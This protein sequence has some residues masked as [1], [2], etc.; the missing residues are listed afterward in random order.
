MIIYD[1]AKLKE[2]VNNYHSNKD[3]RY[4]RLPIEA[5]KTIRTLRLNRKRRR[6]RYTCQKRRDAKANH[7]GSRPENLTKI[8]R[9]DQKNS[10]NIILGTINIQSIKSKELQLIDLLENYSL[11]ALMVTET[12]LTN[13]EHG[14]QWLETTPLNRNP[15]SLVHTN[16]PNGRGGGLALITKNCYT[17]T[18]VKNGQY[19]SFEHATWEFNVKHKQIHITGIYHPPY[20]LR[21]KSTNRAFLDDF[22]TFVTELLPRWSNNLLVGD[23]NLHV[24][25]DDDIDSTIFLDTIEAMGLYQHVTFPTHKQGNTLDLVISELGNTSKVMTTAP[26]PFLTDHRVVIS[27][28]NIKSSQ[29]KRQQIKV[30]K[31]KAVETNQWEKEFNHSN[32]TLT[33][34]LEKDVESLATELRRVLDTLAP[35]KNCSVSL[36]PKKPWFNHDL[37]VEKA[38]VRR[39]EKK[40]LK[41]KLSSTWTAYKKTRNSYYAQLNN[42]KKKNICNQIMDC[43]DD[44]KKRFTLVNNLTNKPEPQKWPKHNTKEDLAEDFA[45]FFQNKILKIRELF[46]GMKQYEAITDSSV[47]LLRKFAP[48]TEKQISL[49]I[50]QMKSKTCELDDIPTNILK[51]ILPVVCP[52]ITKI[53]NTSLTNGEFST[54]WKTAVVRPL[55]KK[56][57]LEL[58]KQNFR[59]VSNLAFISKIVERAMLLQLSQHCQDFNLQPD[60]QSAYRPDYSCE[61]AILKISNDILWAFENK[62]ITALV[63]I[64]LSAAFDTVDHEILLQILN[65][66]Y[67]ITG[68]A[69][70]WFDNYLSERSF[71]VVIGDKY[72]KPHGLTVSVPQGSC[73]GASVFNLYCS[74]LHEIIPKDLTLSGFADDHSVRRTFRADSSKDEAE[75]NRTL[76]NCML[77]IKS[78]MDSMH[79][80]MNP[81]KTEFIYFGSK[82]QLKK[83]KIGSLKVSEDLI[84]RADMIR[85]LGVYLD[86]NLNYK[87]HVTKKCKAAMLNYFKIKSIRPLLDVKTMARLCLSLCISHLDYCNS[88]LYGLPDT[89]FNRLQ[90][91]QN[92]CARLTLRRGKMDSI[93][94][95]LKELHWLPIKQRIQYKILTLTH[96]CV[97]KIGPKYLQDLIRLRPPT[98][99]GLRS[100]REVNLLVRPLTKCKTFADR[101]FSVGAPVLWNALPATM[102]SLNFLKFKKELKTRLFRQAYSA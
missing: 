70:K 101:S 33:S 18:E 5:I 73:A 22:T 25:K 78:W 24:S 69:L 13:N 32:V 92:M 39:R 12:W 88:V 55:L 63:A 95:C 6:H 16:R 90:R 100:N 3:F 45:T 40:W 81:N 48:M 58:I 28:L 66:K 23:F 8:Q 80:K 68:Q 74:T 57:G 79:L 29:S 64:D 85:Y 53:V 37:A 26:G 47:P 60:Y 87:H 49:I 52:L 21:N 86:A 61:M 89:T 10:T 76:E 31:L 34:N 15:Y 38:K 9:K 72:S 43:S 1:Q 98:R 91:I 56:I 44:S 97:N 50:K 82:P 54:K 62:S 36:K 30:R 20:S 93:T 42:S 51:K 67:G 94:E 35:V 59:L 17:V 4:K 2:I 14:T 41:Y 75:T 96:K 65:A 102:R 19:P 71:K 83:C 84:P 11:D 77:N 27:T 99:G 46:N 7:A